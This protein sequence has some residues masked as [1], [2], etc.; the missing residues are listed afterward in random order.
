M[1]PLVGEGAP[2]AL[3][4][5]PGS[6][7]GRVSAGDVLLGFRLRLSWPDLAEVLSEGKRSDFSRGLELPVFV[8]VR[9]IHSYLPP[10]PPFF[11]FCCFPLPC[12]SALEELI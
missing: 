2:S 5:D 9:T 8:A 6:N 12:F 4:G 7:S 1:S 10:P 3:R 11:V